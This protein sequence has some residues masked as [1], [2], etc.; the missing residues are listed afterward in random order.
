M[1]REGGTRRVERLTHDHS[2]FDSRAELQTSTLHL[3]SRKG[4]CLSEGGF[5]DVPVYQCS[6]EHNSTQVNRHL[7]STYCMPD[8]AL[9]QDKQTY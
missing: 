8:I 4:L 3:G 6:S 5:I 1:N 2:E 9:C 7:L